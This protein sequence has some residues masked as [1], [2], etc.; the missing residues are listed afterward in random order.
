MPGLNNPIGIKSSEPSQSPFIT[1][2][3]RFAGG[4]A[5]GGWVELGRTTLGSAGDTISV[6]SLADKRYYM[7][8]RNTLAS[9]NI[10]LTY[11]L[12]GDSGNNYAWRRSSS[13]GADVANG[14]RSFMNSSDSS[15]HGFSVD[16]F[17]N[18]SDKEKL[19][20]GNLVFQGTAGA[21]NAPSRAEYVGK[22]AQSSNPISEIQS[23]NSQSGDYDTGSEVVVLGYDP[24]DTH[25]SGGFWEELASVNASGSSTNL[26]SGTI[27]AKKYLWVQLWTSDVAGDVDTTFNNDTGT[28]YARRY[29]TN[30]GA[31]TT[32][33]SASSLNNLLGAG[34]GTKTFSNTFIINNSANEKLSITNHIRQ[35]AA[36]AATA[37]T[38][39]ENVG[40][41]AN[42][43]AQI[44]EID[45]DSASG[46]FSSTSTLKVWGAN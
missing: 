18:K 5:V 4:G 35:N 32:T 37:P 10:E 20:L 11:R 34:N 26:S 9:G 44:T 15:T 22:H 25:T 13:G 16:Y 2:P 31:D 12:N 29:S 46:N 17:A 45:I 24:T 41:W 23:F 1:N 19:T 30:G 14:S 7:V 42:T 3:Y 33:A 8:L 6:A 21:G 28:N 36:G 38:R 39:M 43:S 27:T 40:K